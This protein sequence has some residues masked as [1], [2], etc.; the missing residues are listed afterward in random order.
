MTHVI[1]AYCV[2]NQFVAAKIASAI[3][4][5]VTV[6]KVVFNN[7]HGIEG[8]DAKAESNKSPI[9]L[10]ISDNFLKSEKCMDN[11]MHIL[12]RLGN[13]KRLIPVITDG[14]YSKD[15]NGHFVNVPTSFDRVSN[16]IQYMNYWQ[17]KYL[18]LRREKPTGSDEIIHSEHVRKVRNISSE[19]GELLRYLRAME[20][21]TYEQFED[22]NFIILYKVLGLQV[23]N[24]AIESL[25]KPEI[26]HTIIPEPEP[27]KIEEQAPAYETI[28]G[29]KD[30]IDNKN[31]IEN[32]EI[33]LPAGLDIASIP[34][35]NLL[36]LN[37][38]E[39]PKNVESV[40]IEIP[41]VVEEKI[42]KS[43]IEPP[44]PIVPPVTSN[45]DLNIEDIIADIKK[46]DRYS[47]DLDE[48]KKNGTSNYREIIDEVV[49]EDS[50]KADKIVD[51]DTKS[52]LDE[53]KNIFNQDKTET[54]ET[55]L[56]QLYAE[57]KIA[58]E[59]PKVEDI[60]STPPPTVEI[61]KATIDV[62]SIPPVSPIEVVNE[63]KTPDPIIETPIIQES[64]AEAKSDVVVS[65]PIEEETIKNEVSRILNEAE[66]I[67]SHFEYEQDKEIVELQEK[68]VLNGIHKAVNGTPDATHTEGVAE[69]SPKTKL[70]EVKE[71]LSKDILNNDL[72]YQYA[73]ELVQNHR[74]HDTIEQ[75]EILI[76]NDRTH[77]EA[78]ILM[79][80]AAEQT[81]DYLLSL[82]CLEKVTLIKPDYPGIFYKLGCLIIEHFK[83]QKRKATHYFKEAIEH[84][85]KNADAYY[86]LGKL[87]SEQNGDF[88][89]II[90]YFKNAVLNNPYHADAAFEL[91]KAKYEVGDRAQASYF[92]N[93]ACQSNPHLKSKLNDEIFRYEEP[94]PEP[95]V[96]DNG[97]TVLITGATSGIGR[98]TAEIFAQHGYRLILTGRRGDRLNDIKNKFESDYKNLNQ[99][100]EFDV[101]SLDAVKKAIDQIGEEWQNVDILIN[102]AGLASGLEPIHE[103]NIEDWEAMIDTNIKGLLYMTRAIAPKMVA[104]RKGHI[105]NLSSIAGKEVYPNG[106][107]YVATKHAVDSLTRA[108]RIDLHKYNI[109]VSQVAPGAV[110]ETEFSLVRFHGD[111][112][113][114]KIYDEFQPLKASDVAESIYF[115]ASRPEYVNIQDITLFGTQQA[116]ANFIDKSG[117]KDR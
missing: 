94:I 12:Q 4:P 18:E 100:L 27:V 63:V 86:Q 73:A 15:G 91:A 17:D 69:K 46:D 16:V 13:A 19:V 90:S 43:Y 48:P 107:V 106:N 85:P 98:A 31:G 87:E 10:L 50:L 80:Y 7:E 117:R 99:V 55:S 53:I 76:E 62:P 39:E 114:A 78:Y 45:N 20:N 59:M 116:G 81:G 97:I 95:Q 23:P 105:I 41:P 89:V 21:Y 108:M 74:Y 93:K 68:K 112:E 14:V 110:E 56:E 61:P 96:N 57:P 109:R 65:M 22:S 40:K 1:L 64:V 104:R 113:K 33:E 51:N 37:I 88:G 67:E 26:S 30:L 52:V 54:V 8:L 2:E 38:K 6:D 24:T 111:N 66:E 71:K 29:H 44:K 92:Y 70:E 49:N 83:N 115:I 77:I 102:N 72:R 3:S 101:R 11:A 60:I 25:K 47:L 58:V 42:D 79:A 35:V 36:N 32:K 84:D 28:N 103:G 75:L 82:S 5:Q 9:L 34:G